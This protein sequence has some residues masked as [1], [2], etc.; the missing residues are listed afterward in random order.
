MQPIRVSIEGWVKAVL[1][2][3]P[4]QLV[5]IADN[6]RV[7]AVLAEGAAISRGGVEA[8]PHE[9]LPRCRVRLVGQ[10]TAR[11]PHLTMT[12]D[13]VELLD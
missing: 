3:W 13:R 7:D 5:V 6:E 10:M 1:E 4:L 8:P 2:S 12:V 9:L 11:A